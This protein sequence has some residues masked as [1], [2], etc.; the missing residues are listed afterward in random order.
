M[1]SM[2]HIAWIAA[3]IGLSACHANEASAECEAYPQSEWM[4]LEL[5]LS[6]LRAEGYAIR[7]FKKNRNCWELDGRNVAGEEVE[8]FFDM[9]TLRPIKVEIDE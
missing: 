2:T 7:R 6:K 1:R 9:K 5:A 3:C 8:V 4:P